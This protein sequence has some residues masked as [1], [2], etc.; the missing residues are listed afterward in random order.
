MKVKEKVR[1][2]VQK[3]S[4]WWRFCMCGM[5]N[6]KSGSHWVTIIYVNDL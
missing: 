1:K 6:A 3:A 2:V 5:G 4:G